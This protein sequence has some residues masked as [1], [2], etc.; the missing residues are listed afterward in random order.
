MSCWY[1][2]TMSHW[3]QRPGLNM[4]MQLTKQG[5]PLAVEINVTWSVDINMTWSV[6]ITGELIKCRWINKRIRSNKKADSEIGTNF[7]GWS[8]VDFQIC[9]DLSSVFIENMGYGASPLRTSV[10]SIPAT[11]FFLSSVTFEETPDFFNDF[12]M[13]FHQNDPNMQ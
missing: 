4:T 2:Q 13:I 9:F 5:R 7:Y 8:G 11:C 3:F 12:L 10:A 1:Q 6:D